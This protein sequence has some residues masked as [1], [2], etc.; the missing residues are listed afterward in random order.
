MSSKKHCLALSSNSKVNSVHSTGIDAKNVKTNPT[1]TVLNQ[2]M[3]RYFHY[4]LLGQISGEASN[5]NCF[6]AGFIRRRIFVSVK[7]ALTIRGINETTVEPCGKKKF[8]RHVLLSGRLSGYLHRKK[9]KI[10]S[11]PPL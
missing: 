4:Q 2:F 8:R 6:N 7:M 1:K 5:I 11:T 9:K 10:S 3:V